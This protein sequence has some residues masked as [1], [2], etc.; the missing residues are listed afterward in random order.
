MLRALGDEVAD[1]DEGVPGLVVRQLVGQASGMSAAE[2][3]ATV[4]RTG[5][6]QKS[7]A[8]HRQR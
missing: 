7:R 6:A 8:R 3:H 1:V 4:R 5:E 2:R